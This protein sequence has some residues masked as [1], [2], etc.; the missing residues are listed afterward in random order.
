[1][2]DQDR[3]QQKSFT[4]AQAEGHG[5]V[6]ATDG[7]GA[8]DAHA[9]ADPHATDAHAAEAHSEGREAEAH[10]A[11]AHDDHGHGGH[12]EHAK[13]EAYPIPHAPP[14]IY[15]LFTAATAKHDDHGHGEHAEHAHHGPFYLDF[16]FSMFYA[17]TFIFVVSRVTRRLSVTRPSR[18][19]S[20]FEMIFEG[21]Y[22]FFGSVIGMEHA[23]KYMPFLGTLFIYIWLNNFAGAIPLLKSPTGHFETTIA[24]GIC[25]FFY[26]NASLLKAGGIGHYL[27]HLAGS[28]AS[29]VQWVFSPLIFCL[30]LV[31]VFVRPISLSL[32]LFGNIMGEDRLVGTFLGL[33]MVIATVI[34]GTQ[35]PVIGVPLHFPFF[36]LLLLGSTIQATVFTLLATVYIGMSLPHDHDHDHEHEHEEGHEAHKAHGHGHAETREMASAGAH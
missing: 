8:A 31:G 11:A 9:P 24:L 22:N 10:A 28:P 19:Q 12:G 1:M 6:H 18:A 13:S 27:W 3:V 34:F 17:V 5:D 2:N 21:V 16:L 33:G 23:R 20:F 35:T 14:N 15:E 4:I 26:I 30:E 32:R 29:A 25:A 36:F 7:H